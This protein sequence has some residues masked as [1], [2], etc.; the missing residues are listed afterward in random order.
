MRWRET[1]TVSHGAAQSGSAGIQYLQPTAM[2]QQQVCVSVWERDKETK[3]GRQG[4]NTQ[5]GNN[6]KCEG[7]TEREA[8]RHKS[9]SG[10]AFQSCWMVH[11]MF[12]I[13]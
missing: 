7:K 13:N 12:K 9:R 8:E 6:I 4:C 1:K 3:E 2:Q 10:N 5:N 11:V